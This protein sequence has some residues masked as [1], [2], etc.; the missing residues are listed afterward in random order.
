M[1]VPNPPDIMQRTG[2]NDVMQVHIH[3]HNV[4]FNPELRYKLDRIGI[5]ERYRIY[6][7]W[8]GIQS[9][10]ESFAIAFVASI[11]SSWWS[12]GDLS[13]NTCCC[14]F[15]CSLGTPIRSMIGVRSLEKAFVGA[16]DRKRLQL[17]CFRRESMKQYSGGNWTDSLC[18]RREPNWIMQTFSL[19]MR[20]LKEE[21]K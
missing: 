13:T 10:S 11:I 18:F 15:N 19:S 20:E 8:D 17:L 7:G 16:Q 3:H 6:A 4:I 14:C 21:I 1:E 9:W 12:L 5:D 2:D